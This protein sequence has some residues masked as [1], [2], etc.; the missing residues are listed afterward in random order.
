MRLTFLCLA[1][2]ACL[3]AAGLVGA[4][5]AHAAGTARQ[6]S[7]C[8]D[9]AYRFCERVVPD[10][11]AVAKCLR[12]NFDSLSRACRQQIA[13]AGAKKRGRHR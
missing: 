2:A 4:D 8:T 3:W 6:R 5:P 7:A 13:G 1:S 11:A 12:A 10:A 9:D